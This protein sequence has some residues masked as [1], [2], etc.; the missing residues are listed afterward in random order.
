MQ[1]SLSK[2]AIEEMGETT[3]PATANEEEGRTKQDCNAASK[4]IDFE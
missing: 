4:A 1:V 3:T 2:L